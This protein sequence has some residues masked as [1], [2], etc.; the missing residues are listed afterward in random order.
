MMQIMRASIFF[1]VAV[2]SSLAAAGVHGQSIFKWV[3]DR[4]VVHY[5]DAPPPSGQR[6]EALS[7][8][9]I[10]TYQT[11]PN[12]ARAAAQMH[13]DYLARRVANLEYEL[14]AQRQAA[15][16]SYAD[17]DAR[18]MQAAYEQCLA[19]RRVDCGGGYA[20]PYPVYAAPSMPLRRVAHHGRFNGAD[21]ITGVTAGNVVTF[22]N[23]TAAPRTGRFA[24]VAA[25][26]R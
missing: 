15:S 12:L 24:P 26:T 3:D 22:R 16:R 1:V 5:S 21:D 9:R 4:G 20:G 18:A 13:S 23:T 19:D 8:D 25:R 6:G 11:D 10:S 14:A 2:A 7:E 17:A